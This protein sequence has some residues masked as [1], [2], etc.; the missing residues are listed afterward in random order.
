M[1]YYRV[2]EGDNLSN[3]ATRFGLKVGTITGANPGIDPDRLRIGQPLRL[4]NLSNAFHIIHQGESLST[5][6]T[7]Y[8]LSTQVLEKANP[9]LNPKRLQIG[10]AIAVPAKQNTPAQQDPAPAPRIA[11]PPSAAPSHLPKAPTP[12]PAPSNGLLSNIDMRHLPAKFFASIL[13]TLNKEGG[14]SRD[15]YDTAH[16]SGVP[17]TNMGITG[18][19]MK[20]HIEATEHRKCS[21]QEAA[22]RIA[23]LT[24]QDAIQVYA[25]GFWR[26]DFKLVAPQVAFIMFDWGVN[27][28]PVTPIRQLQ[29]H[30]HLPVT[31]AIDTALTT[32][33]HELGPQRACE[34]LTECRRNFYEGLVEDRKTNP[35]F[36]KSDKAEEQKRIAALERT[37]SAWL[38]RCEATHQYALSPRYDA[39]TK[40]FEYTSPKGC[41]I[42]DPVAVG[43]VTLKRGSHERSLIRILQER[44]NEV[45]YSLDRDGVW[46]TKTDDAVRTFKQQY[47]LP[48]GLEWGK[49]ETAVLNAVRQSRQLAKN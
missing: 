18:I 38:A 4:P 2:R 12:E 16:Q 44:L 37:G 5:I 9:G 11:P 41:D 8:H 28:G 30:L 40:V 14:V 48:G 46:A 19:A 17:L 43:S 47:N 3:I 36:V 39:L 10:D 20:Q 34:A 33:L 15:K 25:N 29:K 45:G 1:A 6:A 26:E 42:F 7:K 13:E 24:T 32:K 23:T 22:E 21:N 35:R 31:G 49:P 27:S